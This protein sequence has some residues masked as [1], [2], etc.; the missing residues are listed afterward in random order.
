MTLIVG[1]LAIIGSLSFTVVSDV[2]SSAKNEKLSSDIAAINR[3]VGVFL[4]TGG[5]LSNAANADEVLVALKKTLSNASKNPS[6]SGAALDPRLKIEYQSTAEASRKAPRAYWNSQTQKFE[7]TTSGQEPGIKRIYLDDQAGEVDP[8]TREGSFA[9]QYASEDE[10][11]WD[12]TEVNAPAPRGPTEVPV[13]SVPAP[14]TPPV[15]PPTPPT[16]VSSTVLAPPSFSIPGGDYPIT[17]FGL[18]LTLTNPNPAGSSSLYYSVNYGE[19]LPYSGLVTVAPDSHIAAMA[20]ANSPQYESSAQARHQYAA[21]PIPLEKPII[22]PSRPDF[23]LFAGRTIQV[24]ITNPNPAGVS[25]LE[26][27]IGGDPWQPYSRKFPVN[28]NDYP[29][30]VM[31]QARVRPLDPYY[32]GSGR[33]L[34]TL[35]IETAT[36]AGTS[37]GTFHGAVGG[38][39]MV[40][41]STG[42][43]FAWGRD[44]WTA[45]ELATFNK[46]SDA[47]VLSKSTMD[48]QALS[49]DTIETGNASV[50]VR[51][52]T[53]MERW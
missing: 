51:F 5:D 49:Y 37:V 50:S 16:P 53:S 31:I 44:Y 21:T 24:E 38:T 47:P 20:V 40:A 39:E 1:L 6:L 43:A 18:S 41:N 33:T 32:T 28:R 13:T 12:Y 19:W 48:F 22:S 25:V 34:R 23:G 17:D 11:I 36:I 42:S 26:Y 14:T 35:G 45:D 10:W 8:G 52:P 15:I 2:F 3:S 29:A 30:G 27:R 7:I 9:F 4:G 46:P